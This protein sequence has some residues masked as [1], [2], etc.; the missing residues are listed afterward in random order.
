MKPG[1]VLLTLDRLNMG[2]SKS[3]VNEYRRRWMNKE[4]DEEASFFEEEQFKFEDC[5]E[6]IGLLSFRNCNKSFTV[7]KYTRTKKK[8]ATFL[9]CNP[10]CKLAMQS[11]PTQAWKEVDGRI[12]LN[13]CEC[14]GHKGVKAPRTLEAKERF[15]PSGGGGYK[16]IHRTF[17]RSS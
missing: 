15:E 14:G 5:L 1:A 3:V 16:I 11:T 9:C 2:A 12:V 13:Y 8:D 17:R 7:F 4:E 6:N 10:K